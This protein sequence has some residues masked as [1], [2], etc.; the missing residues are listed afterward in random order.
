LDDGKEAG[1]SWG[2][3]KLGFV[4]SAEGFNEVFRNYVIKK[5]GLKNPY[6]DTLNHYGTVDM[7]TMAHE[8]PLSVLLRRAAVND[9]KMYNALFNRP[10]K[11]PTFA[12]YNPALFYFEEDEGNL[13]CS[14]YSG[15][16]LT[17]Y[18]L[19]D[20]GGV[21]DLRR[22]QKRL[23][24]LGYNLEKDI[25][26]A[27]IKDTV[28]NLPFVYV[29]ERHDFS[30]SFYAFQIYPETIRRALQAE[31]LERFLTGKFTMAVNYD[32]SGQQHL[33]IHIELRPSQKSD[34][35]LRN[36]ARR[37]IVDALL[38][39]SS[40]YRETHIMYGDRVYPKITLWPYEDA[41]YFKAGAKQKWVKK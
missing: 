1:I 11:L 14:S 33:E 35:L 12:Q 30:V 6:K 24:K 16:P 5:A 38:A 10:D 7:G 29:Y 31:E 9:E 22:V 15:L 27:D 37:Y 32:N 28:W 39:E 4:F 8:T 25:V 36:R 13:Y 2:D 3:H 26:K 21:I 23:H 41:T 17:R 34:V 18:D 19:K 20:T 40:E